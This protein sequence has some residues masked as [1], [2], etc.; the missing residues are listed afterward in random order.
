MT[1]AETFLIIIGVLLIWSIFYLILI[2]RDKKTVKKLLEDYDENEDKSKQ[3]E[4]Y[5]EG[6]LA[7]GDGQSSLGKPNPIN[8]DGFREPKVL[9][10]QT[11]SSVGK[12]S[13]SKR[14]TSN[15]PRGIFRKL[16]RS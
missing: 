8:N 4:R 15:R 9:P 6:L 13:N 3:G 5:R 10:I 1:A 11:S 2:R 16:R 14:K 12:S 7:G